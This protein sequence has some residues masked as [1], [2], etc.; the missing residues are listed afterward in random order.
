MKALYPGLL[1]VALAAASSLD[2]EARPSAA[3]ASYRNIALWDAAQVPGA[4]G[5]GPLDAPFLTVFQPREGKGNGGAV[6]IGPGGGNIMLMYGAEGADVAEVFNDWG[7]TAFVLTYRLSPR[8]DNDTRALDGKRAMQLVRARAAEWQLDPARIGYIGFSAGGHLGR[9]IVA[10]SGPGD[11]KAADPIE[12][13]SSRPDYAALIYG[14][15]Q[16]TPG[17][18]L[19]D[20]PPTFLLS[21][22]ADQGPSLA[23]AQLF[24]ELT[25]AGAIAEL[26][27]YQRGRHGFGSGYASPEFGDWMPRLEHFLR[28]G[29]FLPPASTAPIAPRPRPAE[30]RSLESRRAVSSV[31]PVNDGYGDYVYV[32]AGAFEMGD[33]IGDG[34]TREGPA[35]LVEID[36]FYIGKFEVSNAEW[37]KFR[38]DPGYDDAKFWPNG[39]A[40]PRDQIPYWTQPNNHGGGTAGSDAYP[41]L[42]I[43]WDAATAYTA[44]LSARTGKRY[45]LPTE[46]EWEK[47]ARGT[48]RRRYP[49]GQTIDHSYAN[50]VGAQTFDTVQPVG[51]Y[52]GSARGAL[53]THSNASPYGAFDMA[54]NVMEWCQDWYARDYY[55]TSPRKNPK[56]PETG[57]YRVLRGGSFFVEAFDLRTYGRSAAW[58][59]LQG[60]RMVGVRAL[61]EP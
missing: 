19:K 29:G 39:R 28:V 7:V 13:V 18:S 16:A 14:A 31:A 54:G 11:A 10:S 34:L 60:H 61:R 12:R 49:W 32:P 27:V 22:A 45:R 20:Y 51:F 26:H 23:N 3:L 56:G 40:V 47:A 48:D 38:D 6:V 9:S 52:D 4:K 50:F 44:W 36:A 55:A 37:K 5:N 8:Y 46:A 58:P 35:H 24:S 57:A 43:N 30:P 17:E 25:K 33:G 2:S 21:A 15:G 1:L 53:Q 59:S 41:A 42:G